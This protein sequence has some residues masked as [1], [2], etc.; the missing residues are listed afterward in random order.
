MPLPH[1]LHGWQ[2][3][4]YVRW[5]D[6]HTESEAWTLIEGGLAHSEKISESEGKE[7]KT[8]RVYI[9]LARTVLENIRSN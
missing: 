4:E 6:E 1:E 2:Q 8:A 9:E 7:G 3:A 5:V